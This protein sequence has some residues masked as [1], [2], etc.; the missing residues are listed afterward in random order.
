MELRE[1][2]DLANENFGVFV[3]EI[4]G[5]N[6]AQF[7]NDLDNILTKTIYGVYKKV[8]ISFSRGHGKSTHISVAYPLWIIAKNHN[9]RILLISSTSD[10]SKSFLS[11]I[12]GHIENNEMY[13]AFCQ[14]ID[15]N[16]RGVIPKEKKFKKTQEKWSGDSITIDRDNLNLKDPTINAV[17]LFGSILAKRADIII[18]DDVV[19][20]QNSATEGQR[21]KVIDWVR[22]TVMPVLVPGG[23]FCY[24]GNTWHQDD[25]VARFMKD[26]QFDYKKKMPAILNESN[27]PDLWNDW[28]QIILDESIEIEQRKMKAEIFYQENRVKMEDGVRVLWPERFTYKE[29]YLI[30]LSDA[31]S[32]ARMYQCDPTNRPDQK[33][34]DEWL[35]KATQKG[36]NFRLQD[37]QREYVS[38]DITTSGVDLAITEKETGDDTVVLTL[39]RIKYSNVSEIKPGDYIIRQIERKKF[40][41]N[42]TR[43]LVSRTWRDLKPD[44]IRVESVAY[45]EAMVRDLGDM[46]IPVHGYHTGGEKKDPNIGVHSLAILLELGKLILPFDNKDPRTISLISQ[47]MNEM[48]AFP[49]GHTGDSLMALWFAFSELRDI[50]GTKFTI[51]TKTLLTV[52][53]PIDVKNPEVL[54]REEKKADLAIDL[55]KKFERQNFN[56]MMRGF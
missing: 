21:L 24:L 10:T 38:I 49:D 44:G 7:H 23:I 52:K 30:R 15:K 36:K 20:Q 22:T 34:K 43:E 41:P 35:E 13:R 12:V 19:N 53:Q 8:V 54:K 16:K 4:L 31:Y 40:S 55:E 1:I 11:E 51:P 45:Q 39:D 42:E 28:A 5:L 37:L 50:S 18:C 25:L 48:R 14:Y 2:F 46:G 9:L 47:L 6:N 33:F 17:G 29:L 3:E 26:P 32:F 56:R 27:Y